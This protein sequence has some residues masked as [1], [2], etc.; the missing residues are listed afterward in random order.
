MA[1]ADEDPLLLVLDLPVTPETA[2][3]ELRES[4]AEVLADLGERHRFDVL[5]VVTELVCNVLDH[6]S[7]TGRLRVFLDKTSGEVVVEVDDDS[8]LP[9]VHGSSR[10]GGDR[11]RGIVMIDGLAG[12]WGTRPLAAGGK[13]V[14]ATVPAG[15]DTAQ[16]P[17]PGQAP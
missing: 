1:P 17:R 5:L 16:D 8:A 15:R 3:P 4:V 7:G 10:L 13:T 9:P 14:F 11:G 12:E 2:T 6:T